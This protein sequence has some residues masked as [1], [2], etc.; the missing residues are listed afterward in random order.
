MCATTSIH[1]TEK[2][3]GLEWNTVKALDFRHLMQAPGPV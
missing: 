2:W 3:N 1:A